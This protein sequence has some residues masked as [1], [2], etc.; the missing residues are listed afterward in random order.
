M[1][2]RRKDLLA[3]TFL[4]LLVTVFFGR[5]VFTDETLITFRLTNVFPWLGEATQAELDQPSVTSDC[6]FSYF[7]RRVFATEMVRRGEMPFWN[8]HQFCGTPF[9]AAFQTAVLYPVNVVLYLFDP[10]TQMD[11]FIY[12]HFLLAAVFT[13][14]LG[15]KLGMSH[16]ASAI[17]AVTFTFCGF[18]VTRYGQPTFVSTAAWLPA[19]L[20]FGEHLLRNPGLRRAGLL[21][22]ALVFCILAGFPQLAMFDI[23]TL[24]AYMLMRVLLEKGSSAS[25]KAGTLGL[26]GLALGVAVLVCAFQLLPTW[27]LST[28]SFRKTLS[29]DMVLSSAHHPLV[30]L[31]YLV[32][33]I[34]G[35]PRDVG[36]LSKELVRG[37][38]EPV[39]QQNYVSTTGYI[40]VF[41]LLLAGVGLLHLRRK[42]V[43]LVILGVVSLLTVFG[44]PL[45]HVFYRILPGFNFSRIDRVIVVYMCS[46]ALLAGYGFDAARVMGRRRLVAAAAFVLFATCFTFWF[47]AAGW[48]A[49]HGYV[50]DAI[51]PEAYF[52]YVSGK[53]YA[54]FGLA[55]GS[56]ILVSL[57]GLRRFPVWLLSGLALG[58]LLVDLLPNG[59]AFKVSQPAANVVPPSSLVDNLRRDRETWRF[60]KFGVEVIPSNTA[61]IV[62]FDDIHGYD[63]LNVNRY[64]EVLGAIDSSMIAVTN[65][66]LRRRIGPI[67]SRQGLESPVLDMLNVKYVLTAADMGG[68]RPEAIALSNP[69]YL[70]RA[71]LVPRA[72]YLSTYE[73]VLAC[74]RSGEFDPASEVLLVG[75][76]GVSELRS[77]GVPRSVASPDTTNVVRNSERTASKA[78]PKTVRPDG[79]ADN[80]GE[81]RAF[82]ATGVA[83][84]QDRNGPYGAVE[85]APFPGSAAIVGLEPN[86]LVIDANAAGDCFLFVSDVHYP[87][88]TAFV[89]GTRAELLR[90]NYAFRAVKIGRGLHSV[91]MEYVPIYFRTGLIFT[92]AGAGLLLLLLMSG[93]A[94]RG[95]GEDRSGADAAGPV[96]SGEEGGRP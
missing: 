38:G 39:F 12:V 51:G 55:V 59:L 58:L 11:L 41:P 31:K 56:G 13:F 10:A 91:R 49:I 34:L 3:L 19:L 78:N 90:A 93:A 52:S 63:A 96:R 44:T 70:P 77:E 35:N 40:G 5:E 7:P 84:P 94:P 83:T 28:F 43:P 6:T 65:A 64:I 9:M 15:R 30:A 36:V 88:W 24:A 81:D 53:V 69:G 22:L 14:L 60:A 92:A 33:D 57:A 4:I 76:P 17:S 20:F 29:Y 74:M 25:R 46:V 54:F 71:Y 1:S 82:V 45:L 2:K 66:A 72:R 42:A 27:E 50:A 89:D 87:G 16:G 79:S 75:T 86:R 8:P 37:A 62:G 85:D 73:A 61:T 32:P 23:Y 18:M 48:K 26:V 67:S 21:G 68:P 95:G 47:R 80:T